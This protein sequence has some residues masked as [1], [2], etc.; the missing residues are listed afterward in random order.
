MILIFYFPRKVLQ[1][2]YSDPE[3]NVCYVINRSILFEI[4]QLVCGARGRGKLVEGNVMV[5]KR[6]LRQ[7]MFIFVFQY[8]LQYL[9][10]YLVL[11]LYSTSI[12]QRCFYVN[13]VQISITAIQQTIMIQCSFETEINIFCFQS[14]QIIVGHYDSL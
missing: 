13:H 9:L 11:H 2:M 12:S 3:E 8:G 14:M 7:N 10:G 4:K 5:G 1:R 6:N